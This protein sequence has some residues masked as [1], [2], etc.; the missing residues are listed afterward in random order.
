MLMN[1]KVMFDPSIMHQSFVT[2]VPHL[3][4]IAGLIIFQFPVLW[5]IIIT[6]ITCNLHQS[7]VT[8]VPRLRG[9]AGLIIFQFPVLWYII[10]TAITCNLHCER[11]CHAILN[12]IPQVPGVPEYMKHF[13]ILIIFDLT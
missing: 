8:T 13:E 12:L 3:R 10:I 5:Y 2:T 1:G 6:A 9:I 7:F 11:Y 4:G